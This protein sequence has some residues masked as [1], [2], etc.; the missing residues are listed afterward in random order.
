MNLKF[1]FIFAG[2]MIL[3]SLS[4]GQ[5][6]TTST[7]EQ[8]VCVP[9]SIGL[10]TTPVGGTAPYTYSWSPATNLSATNIANPV[11]NPATTTTYVVT[12][13][14]ANSNSIQDNVTINV[15]NFPP[16][17]NVIP[18]YDTLCGPD[19]LELN[20]ENTPAC[21]I[22]PAVCLSSPNIA[23]IAPSSFQTL[24]SAINPFFVSAAPLNGVRSNKKQMLYQPKELM[25]Q[26]MDEQTTITS[27]AFFTN[28]TIQS[29]TYDNFS[30]KLR[31]SNDST[32]VNNTFKTGAQTVFEP[33]TV[34][35]PTG[36]GWQ[37][38]QFDKGY[39]WD[40]KSSL[41]VEVCFS[42]NFNQGF[43]GPI[44]QFSNI[45][46]SVL[47]NRVA[48]NSICN[49]TSGQFVL[50][51][52]PNARFEHCRV[53][54]HT[55]L[56]YSW[57]PAAGLSSTSIMNPIATPTV[58]TDYILTA[59][60]TNGC[61]LEDTA[62]IEVA[63]D[64]T[65]TST[66]DTSICNPQN[67]P[68]S[69]IDN[70]GAGATYFW[71][72]ASIM[73]SPNASS[74][75]A[76]ITLS[77]DIVVGVKSAGGCL[78][79]DSF[80]VQVQPPI[81]LEINLPDSTICQGDTVVMDVST[82]PISCNTV[83][84]S[85]PSETQTKIG[86]GTNVITGASVSP[87]GAQGISQTSLKK[88]LMFT[89]SE[90]NSAGIT[91]ATLFTALQIQLS[92]VQGNTL[93][94]NFTIKMGCTPLTAFNTTTRIFESP[95]LT[96]FD[97]KNINISPGNNQFSFDNKFV[98][99]GTSSIV[100]EF[101][102]DN[103]AP[104]NVLTDQQSI[105]SSNSGFASSLTLGGNSICGQ[106]NGGFVSFFRPDITF[107]SCNAPPRTDITY[108]WT[109]SAGVNDDTLPEPKLS[110][111]INT[112]YILTARVK[113]S[114]CEEK[115]TIDITVSPDYAV[116]GSNDTTLCAAGSIP[117]FV[118]SGSPSP[119]SIQWEPS[120]L[121]SNPTSSNTTV[122]LSGSQQLI[123]TLNSLG[124][125]KYDTVEVNVVDEVSS[126]VTAGQ[127]SLCKDSSTNISTY[128]ELACS[129]SNT[130]DCNGIASATPLTGPPLI[131]NSNN[132]TPFPAGFLTARRQILIREAELTAAGM[133]PGSKISSLTFQVVAI[134][135]LTQFE[136]FRIRIGCVSNNSLGNSFLG[137][138]SLVYGPATHN[139]VLGNNTFILDEQYNWDGVSN[140]LVEICYENS[141]F[142]NPFLNSTTVNYT[143]TSYSSTIITGGAS[144]SRCNSAGGSSYGSRPVIEFGF[145]PGGSNYTYS[146]T[147]SASLNSGV[148]SN[149]VARPDTTTNYVVTFTNTANNCEYK[150]SI[151]ISISE[152]DVEVNNDT[153]LCNSLGYQLFVNTDAAN[154]T[155]RWLPSDQVSDSAIPNPT[156]I[157]SFGT[158]YTALVTNGSGCTLSDTV[159]LNYY[160]APNITIT[161]DTTICRNSN[162]NLFVFGGSLYF[163][164]PIKGLDNPNAGNPVLSN[165]D[166]ST[167]Y[168]VEIIDQ[169][170]CTYYD[171]IQ[172]DVFPSPPID[173]GRD[174]AYCS[175][176][177][178]TL[179]ASS[180]FIKYKWSTGDT[181]SS[182]VVTP[183]G[184]Y[185]ILAEDMFGCQIKDTVRYT[186]LPAPVIGFKN[187]YEICEQDSI[188]LDAGNDG[189]SYLWS[190]GANT[191]EVIIKAGGDYWVEVDNGQC[192][193]RDSFE[194]VER[195]IPYSELPDSVEYCN[196]DFPFGVPVIAGPSQFQYVWSNGVR[197][198]GTELFDPG[199]Y[200]VS[201]RN[202]PENC[203]ILDTIDV[204][205]YCGP[206]FYVPNTFTP[207]NDFLN[208]K[209]SI[210][211]R[212][213]YNFK[214]TLY[215]R[216][217]ELIYETDN[218]QFA[219]DGTS[220]GVKVKQDTYLW[221][222]EFDKREADGT[223]KS[224][225]RSGKLLV[226]R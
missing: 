143:N 169:F 166:E 140:L 220:R 38:F 139:V 99:D 74:T 14:D 111:A 113:N 62:R 34:V 202:G 209:F 30:I 86:T 109:P 192:I 61:V 42:N 26:G 49:Q 13:T 108:T 201:I 28:S 212:N 138:T 88:Q 84:S 163:W 35:I 226:L 176:Y 174:S 37:T 130:S 122:T 77:T 52:R 207:N 165:L 131:S 148:I 67:F 152:F 193:D 11:A 81:N 160:P 121:F 210:V 215:N 154:P 164:N 151:E 180:Q 204:I 51:S 153:T 97:P 167:K 182:I 222:I 20:I 93:Y 146:W 114:V 128:I 85:C 173:L 224:D 23:T 183:P 102:Y 1:A 21:S 16:P 221:V 50:S 170:G 203:S 75:N 142:A 132:V 68:L 7:P 56:T 48:F 118:A 47:I 79:T 115:D 185:S 218:P 8:F 89:A 24:S 92:T 31:C 112:Q 149:P 101:C 70:A 137:G 19:T 141:G 39:T 214:F 217:G 162:L 3:C 90:L 186:E 116:T 33:K 29:W 223:F 155:Y 199:R 72:P 136:N 205:Q 184:E 94:E 198:S 87:F 82:D 200:T 129:L 189:T 12:I 5:F 64:F 10:N 95:L 177:V 71:E 161:D 157:D 187:Q 76:N 17:L 134:G 18:E 191:A 83:Q 53:T 172:I 159:F 66:G 150:D 190:T 133:S 125:V 45:G 15:G 206:I 22:A 78:K 43:N 213:I 135:Q 69:V 195:Q 46:Q 194:V 181:T 197:A 100:V 96:V 54:H 41:L 6:R 32:F 40:G 110:P 144:G 55:P 44:I 117:V 196:N 178:G 63:S 156:V 171:S 211:A 36:S 219:W 123:A 175:D 9:K 119:T 179:A 168:T 104:L 158:Y 225:S 188:L 208:D 59:T 124:C 4:Y 107:S 80:L 2:L 145:C 65:I 98:W 73:S 60:D 57:S 58:S 216:W 106:L 126:S 25:D 147:P 103:T 105:P 120:T 127:T 91:D 27:I